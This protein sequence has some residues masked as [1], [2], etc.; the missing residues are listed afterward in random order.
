MLRDLLGAGE[1]PD[2]ARTATML[3]MLRDGLVVG[4]DLDGTAEAR[5]LIRTAVSR[6]IG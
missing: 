2:A 1:H 4:G 5:T 6:V 3:M